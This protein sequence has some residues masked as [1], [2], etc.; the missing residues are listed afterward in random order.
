MDLQ[1]VGFGVTDWIELAQY[2]D[3]L[4]AFVTAVIT[5]GLHKIRGIS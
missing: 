4:W 5:I 1:E 3:S 2:R